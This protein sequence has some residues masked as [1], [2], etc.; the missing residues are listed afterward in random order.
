MSVRIP[1]PG[2][3][4]YGSGRRDESLTGITLPTVFLMLA[5]KRELDD[6]GRNLAMPVI[7]QNVARATGFAW[8]LRAADVVNEDVHK[9]MAEAISQAEQRAHVRLE[10]GEH[11]NE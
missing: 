6:I 8:G 9:A 5:W 1:H 4:Q 10:R 3:P 2:G 11:E 7:L